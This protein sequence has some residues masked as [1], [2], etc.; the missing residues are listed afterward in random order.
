[1]RNPAHSTY[2]QCPP[3]FESRTAPLFDLSMENLQTA[4]SP[5]RRDHLSPIKSSLIHCAFYCSIEPTET[6]SNCVTDP[7]CL[8]WQE[9]CSPYVQ[10]YFHEKWLPKHKELLLE[11]NSQEVRI[12]CGWNW[13][14]DSIYHGLWL[15]IT[16]LSAQAPRKCDFVCQHKNTKPIGSQAVIQNDVF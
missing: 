2:W 10:I 7:G 6:E 13:Q 14:L 15:F 4:L 5:V 9:W 16:F 8:L 12:K 11:L 1:M 3:G